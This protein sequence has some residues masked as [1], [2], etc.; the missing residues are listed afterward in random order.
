[1]EILPFNACDYR[2]E[3]CLRRNGAPC[4]AWG[5][6]ATSGNFA[7]GRETEGI[8]AALRDVG[9]IFAETTDMLLEKAEEMGIDLD[10]LDDTEQRNPF[11]EAKNDPLYQRAY[12]F[13]TM[14]RAF[15]ER[16]EPLITPAAHEFYEDVIWHHTIVPAKT[17]RAI[18]LR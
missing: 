9:E 13:M 4:S 17:F 6:S 7:L 14:T 15:L 12:E 18:G 3:R 11:E 2:C 16:A 1:M 8:E 5:R 10:E